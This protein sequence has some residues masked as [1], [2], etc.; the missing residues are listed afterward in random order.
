MREIKKESIPFHRI[1]K[2]PKPMSFEGDRWFGLYD[3]GLS[4]FLSVI[5]FEQ[6]IRIKSLYTFKEKRNCGYA[7]EL[8]QQVLDKYEGKEFTTYAFRTSKPLFEDAGFDVEKTQ[9]A[10]SW[11]VYVMRRESQ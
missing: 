2:K 6:V 4:S 10:G 9:T 8:V 3:D 1:D 11:K 7:R 5:E